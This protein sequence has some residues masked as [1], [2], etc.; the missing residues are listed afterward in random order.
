MNYL[1][2]LKTGNIKLPDYNLFE[3]YL[4][5]YINEKSILLNTFEDS[6]D[7]IKRTNGNLADKDSCYYFNVKANLLN[8]YPQ[9][10]QLNKDYTSKIFEEVSK[11]AYNGEN[12]LIK[13]DSTYLKIYNCYSNELLES[14]DINFSL[15]NKTVQT[16]SSP[17]NPDERYFVFR[18]DKS[19]FDMDFSITK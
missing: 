12:Y 3:Q 18:V 1:N 10:N 15:D 2:T 17:S 19:L 6:P 5:V 9:S 13:V 4:N 16:V 14:Y 7:N 8:L 11:T